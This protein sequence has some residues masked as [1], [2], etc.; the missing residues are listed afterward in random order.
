MIDF[1]GEVKL[2]EL[3]MGIEKIVM[4]LLE[5]DLEVIV[6]VVLEG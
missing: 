3:N 4:I 1:K 6:C 2:V 5:F